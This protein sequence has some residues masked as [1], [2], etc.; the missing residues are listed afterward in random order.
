MSDPLQPWKVR[1]MRPGSS[2]Y[3]ILSKDSD[4]FL[5]QM[6]NN[7]RYCLLVDAPGLQCL[8]HFTLK[9]NRRP[10][11]RSL[12][13]RVRQITQVLGQSPP[14]IQIV[15]LTTA[16]ASVERPCVDGI[17]FLA[18]PAT[19]RRAMISIKVSYN[20]YHQFR[21]LHHS[22]HPSARAQCLMLCFFILR[23]L[24]HE[25]AQVMRSLFHNE[26]C[27]D[28]QISDNLFTFTSREGGGLTGS[29]F[30]GEDI[31][32]MTVEVRRG[33]KHYIDFGRVDLLMHLASA[34]W[35][36][37]S[38]KLRVAASSL[39]RD[40]PFSAQPS[41]RAGGIHDNCPDCD[42]T[43][44]EAP[45]PDIE[46]EA[47]D[48]QLAMALLELGLDDEDEDED[49]SDS[50]TSFSSSEDEGPGPFGYH[51]RRICGT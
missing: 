46:D 18:R 39:P 41:L 24:L 9:H 48:E 50:D 22:T 20:L 23:V 14:L 29:A 35:S 26:S 32:G 4:P 17:P 40:V 45:S 2:C 6:L 44:D 25:L 33:V 15:E 49:D 34:E 13:T 19:E 3:D 47:E 31:T 42:E 10:N 11:P 27:L 21:L 12:N 16:F 8:A 28:R 7:L 36:D 1:V 38:L 51:L 37:L 30:R 43:E 5:F